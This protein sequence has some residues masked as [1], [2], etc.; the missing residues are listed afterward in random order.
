[1]HRKTLLFLLL[2][3]TSLS[4]IDATAQTIY[5]QNDSADVLA[6]VTNAISYDAASPATIML[7]SGP[8]RVGLPPLRKPLPE[9]V[10]PVAAEQFGVQGR[11]V[12]EFVVNRKGRARDIRILH[13]PGR[14]CG[15]EVLRVLRAARFQ[16]ALDAEGQPSTQRYV[17]AFVFRLDD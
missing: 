11:V 14:G 13:S 12:A 16:P 10:Y 8:A 3:G 4:F 17:T 6:S 2:F 9:P 7:A 15:D 1:M 5:V